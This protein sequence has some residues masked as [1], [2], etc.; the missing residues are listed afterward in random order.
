MRRDL[1]SSTPAL[2]RVALLVVF[3]GLL[4]GCVIAARPI[5]AKAEPG[6]SLV[7][8]PVLAAASAGVRQLFG[9]SPQEAP[10][11][12]WGA[13]ASGRSLVRYT[14]AGG[15][16]RVPMPVDE[17]GQ[18]VAAIQVPNSGQ[19]PNAMAGRTTPSGGVAV[20]ASVSAQG[21]AK[22]V[23]VRD[24]GGQFRAAPAP[25]PS[26][27]P[28]G[29]ELYV[30]SKG[31]VKL[32]AVEEASGHTGAFVV[33]AVKSLSSIQDGLLHFDGSS[34]TRERICLNAAPAPCTAVTSST[35]RAVAI[36]ASG[37]GNAWLLVKGAAAGDGLELFRR[38]AGGV[39]RPQ[40]LGGALGSLFGKAQAEP[41]P[42]TRVAI[43]AREGKGQA[44]TVSSAGVWIDATVKA[45]AGG[46]GESDATVYYDLSKGEVTGSWCDM[47]GLSTAAQEKLCLFPL[48]SELPGGEGRSF[49]WPPVDPGREPF[50]QRA[51]TGVG[52]GAML[53]LAGGSFARIPLD[54]NGGA[55]AGAAL[56]APDQGWL[57]P[58][59]RLTRTPIPSAL[60]SWPLPFRRPLIAVAPQPD[61]SVGALSSQAL[62]VGDKGEV[63][64]YIPG[65]GWEPEP[66]LSGSGA[67]AT[68]RLRAVAWPEPERAFAVGDSGAMWVWRGATGLWEPD[69]GAPTNLIR[70]NFTGIA[71]DPNDPT[72]G[73]AVGKQGLLL[74]Y[75]REW[76]PEAL[77]A[78]VNP[79]ANIT[80]IAFAGDE[81]LATYDIPTGT[82]GV[83]SSSYL[84]GL[85]VNDGDGSGWKVDS[86]A[87][88]ALHLVEPSSVPRRVAGLPDGGA[89]VAGI[90]G[91]VI[92]RNGPGAPW[93]PVNGER[94]GYPV[95][96]AAV[97][98]GGQVRAIASVQVER[99]QNLAERELST[100]TEQ[101]LRQPPP[102]QPPLLTDPYPLPENGFLMRQTATGWRDEEHQ[103]FPEPEP[104]SGQSQGGPLDLP[105]SP[106]PVLALLVSPNGSEGWAVGG[107][108]GE[109]S[110]PP[111]YEREA[112]Q[113]AAVM[114]F[115]S[116]A[117]PPA[118]ASAVPIVP[119][120][121]TANFAVGGGAQCAGPCADLAGTGI[122]P[123]VSLRA[124][125]SR[126][127]GIAGLRAFLYTGTSVASGAASLSRPGFSEEEAAYA[128]RLQA[129]AGA[130]PVYTAPAASDRYGSPS[131]LEAFGARFSGF[132]E[133]LGT[134]PPP[135]GS[136]IAPA[137]REGFSYS[138][139]SG[140]SGG[141]VR[142]IVLDYSTG[143]LSPETQ[144]WLA[145]QLAEA[146]AALPPRPAIVVG[147]GPAGAEAVP[148]LVTG[149]LSGCVSAQ[150][151]GAASAY[152]TGATQANEVSTLS[153]GG[154]SIPSFGT[155]TLG[156]LNPTETS[157][158]QY[159]PA[160]GF[161]LAS[162]DVAHRSP[163]TNVAPVTALL[164][165]SIEDLALEAVDGTLLRRSH[166]ALFAALARR[167]RSGI[168]CTGN[169]TP[170]ICQMAA[171]D[172]YLPIPA[173][174]SFVTICT[175]AI[176]PSYRF[177]S[178]RPD[179]ANFV[180]VDPTSLN[181]RAVYLTKAGKTVADPSSGLL[182]AYNAGT[183]TVTIETGGLAYSEKVT[184]QSGSV[185][186]PCGTVPLL[187]P[188]TRQ[189]ALAVPP[190]PPSPA[191]APTFTSP[192]GALPPPPPP[193]APTP[194]PAPQVV[195][196]HPVHHPLP[197]PFFAAAPGLT[198][199]VAIVPPPPPPAA[200]T[201]PPSGTSPVT[202]P[203]VSPEPEEEDEA[204]LDLVHHMAAQRA[205][206]RRPAALRALSGGGEGGGSWFSAYYLLPA[207]IL[208][209]GLAATSFPG[210]RRQ[211]P[212][213]VYAHSTASRRPR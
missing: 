89:A 127:A 29:E 148:I 59:Y 197:T 97:R 138:F 47:P 178:S 128:R 119:P 73:Y 19:E 163:T 77:P 193:P 104:P 37:P 194:A 7:A 10:G 123:D 6:G 40:V 2:R 92:E 132:D 142:V 107:E 212:T 213:P 196:H 176:Q 126:A 55:A 66:L 8:E 141:T 115:G 152:F 51:I 64:R 147:G 122:T 143:S 188:P 165:P 44:L 173:N 21:T 52:R 161:L 199:I 24:P 76:T 164:I 5:A 70:G 88:E 146:K 157:H 26:L 145:R 202:Q 94:L 136:G 38:E 75:G 35:L 103:A 33:P 50:G 106:D 90:G 210:S 93:S 81:A 72:R 63:A 67:R 153:A 140:G 43:A 205:T 111:T 131:S 160:S 113:T 201:T 78:G 125:V 87:S 186:R 206:R 3:A 105:R 100:D 41:V 121:G 99:H 172:P 200:Q 168:R 129:G 203:A 68:P 102:G 14:E 137:S 190:P 109:L 83:G 209:A 48:G 169:N 61:A 177:S 53:I 116:N 17:E 22:T 166:V 79:E 130:L 117:A 101:A 42:G 25:G 80:S 110:G 139:D 204:A 18:P 39:W 74:S 182:C 207:L 1:D 192:P 96:L 175:R 82:P 69:P 159:A 71:F 23:L 46:S 45:T 181:P 156:Y 155:G 108:T 112:L 56:S 184:V 189:P 180:K 144:C 15:W 49:A 170:R 9:A 124:A 149:E 208:I 20:A 31:G 98:E 13:G 135:P 27:L 150:E 174:C 34:W 12:V 54:G 183:T 85:L 4:G 118:N 28:N 167:P 195:H 11:E 162:V 16:E 133:P 134:V 114:R 65:Q 198:P 158:N 60:A 120:S 91:G 86:Q 171:S 58:S 211:R 30:A 32:A 36:D 154:R 95:A 191:P 57:G 187:N 179:I 151:A 84:G 62:A 185:Q